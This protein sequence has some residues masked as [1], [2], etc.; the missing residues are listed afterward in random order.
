VK[1]SVRRRGAHVR[2]RS[3]YYVP[4]GAPDTSPA[5]QD[6]LIGAIRDLLPRTGVQLQLDPLP[7][8]SASSGADI[9][10]VLRVTRDETALGRSD[11][12]VDVL[13]AVYDD[14]GRA[15]ASERR[16]VQVSGASDAF[17]ETFTLHVPSPGSYQV[18]V[19]ALDDGRTGSVYTFADVPDF[20]QAP[21]SLSGVG[22]HVDP[23][24]PTDGTST[25]N[26]RTAS[27]ALT[28]AR[29]F[30]CTSQAAALA[31]VCQS[32]SATAAPVDVSGTVFDVTGR[33]VLRR[34]DTMAAAS[35]AAGYASYQIGLPLDHLAP[36]EYVLTID[37]VHA[38]ARASRSVRFQVQ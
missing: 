21:V 16:S 13:G 5:P 20:H 4:G 32:T 28:T 6:P 24:A 30:D 33:S 15:V 11:A 37:A 2:T 35:F 19:A 14:S 27:A 9:S 17:E 36:G 7:F 10:L 26:E 29:T 18:R 12:A 31:Y 1:I 3:G 25:A 8:P 22:I 34:T 38:T 23:P